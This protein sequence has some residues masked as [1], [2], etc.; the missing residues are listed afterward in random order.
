MFQVNDLV[1]AFGVQGTVDTV[2][3]EDSEVIVVFENGMEEVFLLDGKLA[4]WHSGPTLTLIRRA[5]PRTVK[6]WVNL[7]EGGK[8]GT[9]IHTTKESALAKRGEGVVSTVELTG[10]VND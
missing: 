5:T 4:E 10:S 6:G 8:L 7:Y 3:T 1:S 2:N 9:R